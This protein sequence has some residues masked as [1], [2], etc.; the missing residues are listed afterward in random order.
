[1]I[2]M[3]TYKELDETA[4]QLWEDLDDVILKARTDTRRRKLFSIKID[5]V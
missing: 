5:S 4:K 2:V 3:Q 1:M